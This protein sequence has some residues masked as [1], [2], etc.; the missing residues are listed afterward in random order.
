MATRSPAPAKP[1]AYDIAFVWEDNRRVAWPIEAKIVATAGTRAEYV[2]DTAKFIDGRAAPFVGEGAQIA[3]LLSGLA[4]EFFSNLSKS[5]GLKLQAVPEFANRA[6]HSSDHVR[7]A[8]PDLHLH[9]LAMLCGSAHA[10]VMLPGF[11][12]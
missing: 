7:K 6:H 10:Q 4:T 3:Y 12:Q 1:P 11:A 2:K 9:H 8:A 5:L